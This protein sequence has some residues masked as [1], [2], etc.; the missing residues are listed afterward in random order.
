MKKA[1]HLLMFLVAT[2]LMGSV[3][4]QDLSLKFGKVTDYEVSLN[5]YEPDSTASAVWLFK[6][7]NMHYVYNS[8]FT[9]DYIVEGKLKVLTS[10]GTAYANLEIPYGT[11]ERIGSLSGTVYN[12]ENGKMVKTKLD[13][14]YVFEEKIN[15]RYSIRKISIPA[16]KEGSVFEFRYVF[17]SKNF[18]PSNYYMQTDIPVC[19]SSVSVTVPEY[20]FLNVDAKGA[21]PMKSS[22]SEISETYALR[23]KAIN[24]TAQNHNCK[25]TNYLFSADSI[26]ALKKDEAY[27]WSPDD[28]KMQVGFELKGVQFPYEPYK[29]YTETW[30]SIDRILLRSDNMGSNLKM[31]NPFRDEMKSWNLEG[32]SRAEIIGKVFDFVKSKVNWNGKY[33]LSNTSVKEVIHENAGSNADI[34]YILMAAL[35][36][37]EIPSVPVM[38]STRHNGRLPYAVPSLSALNTFILC[39]PVDDKLCYLDGSMNHMLL[40]M[41]PG[42]LQVKNARIL[43][44]GELLTTTEKDLFAEIMY[45]MPANNL[46]VDL[47]NLAG[48]TEIQTIQ[49]E[50]AVDGSLKGNMRIVYSG[51]NRARFKKFKT[52][53]DSIDYLKD[54]ETKYKINIDG[55]SRKVSHD[56]YSEDVSFEKEGEI[57]GDNIYLNPMVFTHMAVNNFKQES[58]ILPVEFGSTSSFRLNVLLKLPE[59]YEIEELPEPLR[60]SLGNGGCQVTYNIGKNLG[61]LTLSYN[62]K[63]DRVFFTSD[64]Y[65]DLREF[66]SA[67]I[68]KNMEMVVLKKSVL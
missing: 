47:E 66:F 67:L 52:E 38:M 35:R 18:Y 19:H 7:C 68:S 58:R 44:I 45:H 10:D 61:G 13:K 1:K 29:A 20:I 46:W 11:G 21:Y 9:L 63:Q 4:A 5:R 65:V 37:M 42:N 12:L 26:P 41:L 59:G 40:N 54:I 16:V 62:F 25:A 23:S 49:G 34:N 56:R 43:N 8:G 6:T 24:S 31:K 3:H 32:M 39:V 15:D 14:E 48:T 30:A 27:L 53:Q 33:N 57:V 36:D 17:H 64:E 50:L 28:Y 55:F 2:V 51:L 22:K 60:L